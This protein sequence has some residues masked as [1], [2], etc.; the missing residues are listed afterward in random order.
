MVGFAARRGRA[1]TTPT[2]PWSARPSRAWPT[3]PR[4]RR[5]FGRVRG[6]L[7][8]AAPPRCRRRIRLVSLPMDDL[9][10]NAAMVNALQRQAT[11]IVQK[12]LAE[13]FGLTVAEGMW[14]GRSRW[15][16]RRWGASW[17]RSCPGRGC[18]STTPPT[19]TPSATRW[20]TPRTTP[21]GRPRSGHGAHRHVLDNFLGDRH[22]LQW[23]AL[24]GQL[25]DG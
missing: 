21:P 18:C 14:K 15:W 16:P 9:D 19:S 12:S 1:G 20:R 10:E 13:G 24:I 25:L 11:V 8:G 22:L 6:R 4:G 23:A 7:G 17:T 2:W 5:C 3:T